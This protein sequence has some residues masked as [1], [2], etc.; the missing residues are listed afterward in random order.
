[1][2]VTSL[3]WQRVKVL[4]SNFIVGGDNIIDVYTDKVIQLNQRIARSNDGHQ[5]LFPYNRS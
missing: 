3:L 5:Q 1:M 2:D 4:C